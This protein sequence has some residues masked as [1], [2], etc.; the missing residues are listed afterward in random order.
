MVHGL[1]GLKDEPVKTPMKFQNQQVSEW[2]DTTADMFEYILGNALIK[3]QN[4]SIQGTRLYNALEKARN[5]KGNAGEFIEIEDGLHDWFKPIAEQMTPV[6][7]R[8]NGNIVYEFIREGFEK[9]VAP[10]P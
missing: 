8:L 4:D 5:D 3:T 9:A 2:G 10:K 7:F 6:L 1:V